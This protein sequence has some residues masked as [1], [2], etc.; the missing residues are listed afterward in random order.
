M[1]QQDSDKHKCVLELGDSLGAL[2]CTYTDVRV[3]ICVLVC[4]AVWK[5]SR[6]V[7]CVRN[8]YKPMKE[9]GND[10]LIQLSVENAVWKKKRFLGRPKTIVIIRA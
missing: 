7:R 3:R 8:Q 10:S 1:S 5:G 2:K 9:L 6:T 4:V